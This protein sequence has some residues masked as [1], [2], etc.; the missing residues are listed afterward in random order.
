M[1][2][3]KAAAYAVF[4]TIHIAEHEKTGPVHG[5]AIAQACAI[6][7]EYLR[8]ILQQLVRARVLVSEAGR[9]GGF[10]M[11]KAPGRTT[12]LEIVEAID[13]AL[14]GQLVTQKITSTEDVK[15]RLHSICG[16]AARATKNLLRETTIKHLV[17]PDCD[18]PQ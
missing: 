16:Q 17:T 8:K 9:R 18:S 13:G 5:G 11:R 1:R 15:G 10:T 7:P 6:P 3:S 12:L 14:D 2:L 4:A